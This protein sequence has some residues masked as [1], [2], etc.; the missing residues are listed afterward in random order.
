MSIPRLDLIGIVV[1]DMARSLAFHRQLGLDVPAQADNQPHAELTLAGGIRVAWDTLEEVRSFDPEFRKP[2]G[3]GIGLAFLLD[4]PADVDATYDR[5]VAAGYHG[6][7]GPLECVL[8]PAVRPDSRSRRIRRQSVRGADER[9]LMRVGIGPARESSIGWCT[10]SASRSP[11]W[12]PRRRAR[13]DRAPH[14]RLASP[15]LS[16]AS[17][18]LQSGTI[19][20]RYLPA[21]R[22]SASRSLPESGGACVP[23]VPGEPISENIPSIPAGE[24]MN[25]M[26][27]CLS[28]TLLK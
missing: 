2:D 20:K 18:R 5:L 21:T 25:S 26:R 9:R 1:E 8:G 24:Y 22:P 19:E 27:A 28:P 6:P 12:P 11:R 4:T 7:Q 15:P 23:R 13:A 16:T 14:H 17:P 10:T 3:S